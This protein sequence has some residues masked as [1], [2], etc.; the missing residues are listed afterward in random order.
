MYIKIR[1]ILNSSEHGNE[2]HCQLMHVC[3]APGSVLCSLFSSIPKICVIVCLC[4]FICGHT[5]VPQTQL[6]AAVQKSEMILDPTAKGWEG[7]YNPGYS[8]NNVSYING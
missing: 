6:P 8:I 5:S 2:S 7:F 4:L 3:Y 1:V